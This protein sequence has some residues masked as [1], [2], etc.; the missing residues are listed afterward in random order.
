MKLTEQEK[1]RLAYIREAA[2]VN[3]WAISKDFV[4]D[5]SADC[6]SWVCDAFSEYADGA[7]SVY[8]RDHLNYFSEHSDECERSLLEMYGAKSLAEIIE[9]EGLI[10]LEAKAAVCCMYEENYSHLD[11]DRANICV[12]LLIDYLLNDKTEL[13]DGL[14][15]DSVIDN[16]KD[17]YLDCERICDILEGLRA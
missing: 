16:L 1:E 7:I 5:Y 6:S 17:N 4:G 9:K 2:Y 15:L 10:A 14:D 12:C 3:M 8:T 13:E 11:E